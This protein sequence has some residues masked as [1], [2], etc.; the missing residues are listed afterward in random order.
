[1][2]LFKLFFSARPI[3]DEA[4]VH[5]SKVHLFENLSIN[6]LEELSLEIEEQNL[7][8]QTIVFNEG[9]EPNGMY[10]I[11]EG[12]VNIIKKS[13]TGKELVISTLGN[14]GY[15]GEMA[16]ID[17]IKRTATI[18]TIIPTKLY[19]LSKEH[20]NYMLKKN[21]NTTIKILFNLCRSLSKKLEL[22]TKERVEVDKNLV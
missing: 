16:L 5:L 18:K 3:E 22:T 11:K 2:N 20:F 17:N 19:F 15:F 4:V 6:D 21:K 12:G 9:D 13:D 14:Y 8:A 7:D 10:I 1:M